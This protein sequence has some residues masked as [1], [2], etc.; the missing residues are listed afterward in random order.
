L[1]NCL[2]KKGE[3]VIFIDGAVG[4]GK[5]V[6]GV[7]YSVDKNGELLIV[8]EGETETRSFVT[9]ETSFPS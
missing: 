2:Y 3:P 9:G 1:E 5:K 6:T 4:S 7:L 8:P